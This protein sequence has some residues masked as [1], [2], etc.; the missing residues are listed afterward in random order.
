MVGCVVRHGDHPGPGWRAAKLAGDPGL[1]GG[2]PSRIP[3]RALRKKPTAKPRRAPSPREVLL[4]L[5]SK[6]VFCGLVGVEAAYQPTNILLMKEKLG[7]YH[8]VDLP[9]ARREVPNLLD[10]Y[11]SKHSVYGLLEVDVTVARQ[12]I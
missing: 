5:F 7:P 12:F 8:V 6:M 3:T 2:S 4:E 1:G 9:P 11:W 10:L